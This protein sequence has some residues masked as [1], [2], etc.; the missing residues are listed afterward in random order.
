[1]EGDQWTGY[2]VTVEEGESRGNER[3][4]LHYLWARVQ[5]VTYQVVAAGSDRYREALREMVLSLRPLA[6]GDWG[7]IAG[8]RVRVVEARDGET[9]GQLGERTGNRWTPE[10]TALVNNLPPGQP[11]RP[12]TLIKMVRR[13]TYRPRER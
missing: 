2:Y 10:Y 1:M 13:E 12:G 4:Y 6:E 5:G 11:L 9:F 8:L 7:S 3:S